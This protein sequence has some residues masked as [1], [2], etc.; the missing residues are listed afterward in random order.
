MIFENAKLSIASL[1]ANKMRTILSL[2]G[3]VIGI[4]SVI[5]I[6]NLG[7]SLKN[8]V[9]GIFDEL[10]SD[11]VFLVPMSDDEEWTIEFGREIASNIS[12]VT[13]QTSTAGFSTMAKVG[14]KFPRIELG[15][16]TPEYAEFTRQEVL[17]GSFF[18]DYDNY[19]HRSVAVLGAMVAEE[20]F[21]HGDAIGQQIKVYSNGI[22]SFEVVGV[23]KQN[24]FSIDGVNNMVLIPIETMISNISKGAERPSFYIFQIEE[25]ADPDVVGTAIESHADGIMG[26]DTS[27]TLNL[28]SIAEQN[29]EGMDVMNLVLGGIAAISLL[30]GGIGIMNIMLVSVSERIKEIGIRKALGATPGVVLGQFLIESMLLTLFGGVIGIIFGLLGSRTALKLFEME[31]IPNYSF[32]AIAVLFSVSIGVFFGIY[33]AWRAAKLDPIEALNHE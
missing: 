33:P 3:I 4:S 10:G 8:Q 22:W 9:Q 13:G 20:L 16:A 12:M 5:L 28:G 31:F 2:L 11:L 30:V 23:L 15:G 18:T 26:E 1:F 14:D 6:S 17:Q 25:G 32:I 21:P 27:F 19:A 7:V 29:A 24:D